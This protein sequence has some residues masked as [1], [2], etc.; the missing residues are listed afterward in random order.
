M[1]TRGRGSFG[2]LLGN[3][4]QQRLFASSADEDRQARQASL[5]P[6]SVSVLGLALI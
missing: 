6:T 1:L 2:S 4:G 5:A 3:P